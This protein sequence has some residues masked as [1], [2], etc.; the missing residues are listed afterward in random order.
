MAM[1]KDDSVTRGSVPAPRGLAAVA[2]LGALALG[3]VG[4]VQWM[5][6]RFAGEPS[7]AGV[8]ATITSGGRTTFSLSTPAW[9]EVV[10]GARVDTLSAVSGSAARAGERSGRSGRT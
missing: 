8:H 6:D 5:A 4:G 3:A 7:A 2:L 1:A 9:D 10:S